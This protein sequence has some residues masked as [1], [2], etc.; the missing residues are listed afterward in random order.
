MN[1][2]APQD[3]SQQTYLDRLR[4]AAAAD[5]KAL[6]ALREALV[7][8]KWTTREGEDRLADPTTPR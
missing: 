2:P 6:M 4:A 7:K 8:P 3:P 5:P 1:N